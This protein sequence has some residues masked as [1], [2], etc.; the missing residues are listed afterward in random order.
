MVCHKYAA[1]HLVLGLQE[2]RRG[3]VCPAG[4][5]GDGERECSPAGDCRT[6]EECGEGEQCEYS[7]QTGVF[8]CQ[9]GPRTSV[10]FPLVRQLRKKERK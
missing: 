5:T 7:E 9:P 3:C 2:E 1:C 8:A 6:T 10:S 4:F